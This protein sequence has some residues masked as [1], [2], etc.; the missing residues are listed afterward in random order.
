M[1]KISF[2]ILA[3]IIPFFA[4]GQNSTMYT[5]NGKLYK[6]NGQKIVLRGMN[7]NLLDNGNINFSPGSNSYKSYIDQVAL[8]GA[9]SIRIPWFTNEFPHWRKDYPTTGTPQAAVDNG[10]LSNLL[11][12]CHQKGLVPILELHDFTCDN[13]WSNFMTKAQGWWFQ[14]KILNLIEQHKEYLIINIANEFGK[15]RWTNNPTTSLTTFK[16]N[17]KTLISAFRTKGIKVPI[18]IDAPDCGQ[19]SSELVQVAEE[20]RSADPLDKLIFSAHSYWYGYAPTENEVLS[21]IDETLN[22]G[23]TFVFGEISNRQDVTGNQAD[24]VYNIDYT[25]QTI[26]KLSCQKEVSW[27][28]WTFNHDWHPE[29]KISPTSSVSNLTNFGK[30]VLYNTQYGLLSAPCVTGTLATEQVKIQNINISPNPARNFVSVKGA[31]SNI[32]S[33]EFYQADGRRVKSVNSS[34]E[35]ISIS[36]LPTGTYYLLIKA[37]SQIST[38]KLIIE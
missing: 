15:V 25:Y 29:R 34:F 8:T 19:S 2:I 37:N 36:D 17:Y 32:Q 4:F 38:H 3:F 11:S 33:V 18:M 22:S 12:Y 26:M 23:S 16:N 9:N 1:K 14:E 10:Q 31:N 28:V 21:K 27:L 7:Y 24:G 30:D 5:Q 20:I 6:N 13:S 35:G